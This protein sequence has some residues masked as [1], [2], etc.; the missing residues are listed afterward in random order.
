MNNN[1]GSIDNTGINGTENSNA[2][3]N[4]NPYINQTNNIPNQRGLFPSQD[5][6]KGALIGVAITFL[7][8]NKNAQNTA[9]KA[10]SKGTQFFQA[11][12]EEMKERYEDIKA[13]MEA[14]K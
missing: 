13:Q 3:I 6:V 14:S 1:L 9:I 11:T 5:F 10:V 7:L 12:I 8:T 2:A 4:Q